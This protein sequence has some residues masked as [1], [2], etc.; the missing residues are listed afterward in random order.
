MRDKT[1]V[2]TA[3]TS[4]IGH[5]IATELVKAGAL[6]VITGRDRVKGQAAA[7]V[8]SAL[9][10][11]RAEFEAADLLQQD[12]IRALA[13]RLLDRHPRIDVL[14][15]NAGGSFWERGVSPDGIE[16]TLALNLL[17]PFLLTELL[18]PRL[19]ASAPARIVNV[20]TKL[21]RRTRLDLDDPQS[22]HRYSGFSAYA[23]AK[24]G[25]IGWTLELSRRLQGTGIVVNA[26]HPGVVPETDFG[27]DMPSMLRAIGPIA[28]RLVGMYTPMSEAVITPTWLA[29]A[30]QTEHDS[31]GYYIKQRRVPAP[32]QAEDP[33]QAG[34]VWQLCESLTRPGSARI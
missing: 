22:E 3:A 20:A 8:L 7:S 5:G 11:G 26:A 16:R 28:A 14:V 17:A 10:P 2:I 33:E 1:C 6:V 32:R 13:E 4:G 15:N 12:E 18:L 27:A 31:G 25:L 21:S 30:P 24:A 9:G 19:E 34:R 23:A 29:A